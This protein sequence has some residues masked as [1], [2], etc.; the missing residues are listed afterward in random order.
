MAVNVRGSGKN[1]PANA[2]LLLLKSF[3]G[4][5]VLFLPRAYLNGGMVFSNVVLV[6]VALLS[7]YCFVLLVNTRLNVEG[8][9]GDMGGI[10][11]GKWLRTLILASIVISQIGFVA[12]YIVFTSENLTP[13]KM[14]VC[15]RRQV[16]MSRHL[17]LNRD[18]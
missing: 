4:T 3:V 12:A 6:G 11:Y 2:M 7:Y 8:S 5:G 17:L 13:Y 15:L 10:L 18:W 16:S 1:S 14:V 9:F